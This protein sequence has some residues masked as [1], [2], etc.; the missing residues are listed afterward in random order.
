MPR[1]NKAIVLDLD[2]TLIHTFDGEGSGR[3]DLKK[4][5]VMKD[6]KMQKLRKRIYQ[7]C[8]ECDVERGVY[9]N[10]MATWGIIR[11]HAKEFLEFCFDY[12]KYVIVWTAGTRPYAEEIV[13]NLF[14]KQGLPRPHLVW[15]AENC[16]GSGSNRYKPITLLKEKEDALQSLPDLDLSQVICL[17]DSP[18]SYE[19]NPDNAIKIPRFYPCK[20][21]KQ[22]NCK[23]DVK[24][25]DIPDEA[26]LQVK[27]WLD[28][29]GVAHALDVRTIKVN[30][31]SARTPR[32]KI[33]IEI[34]RKDI[35]KTPVK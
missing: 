7:I 32:G 12:F 18:H 1:T 15:A 35:F 31:M 33:P 24:N 2:L 9:D 30:D 34:A 13:E 6:P 11:P 27:R 8:M 5:N 25:L 16:G 14:H 28:Q 23:Y 29:E 21:D 26:L 3:R 4:T 10:D 17:D 20:V 19:D 22:E